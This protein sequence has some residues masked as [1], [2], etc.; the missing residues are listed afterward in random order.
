M[1]G[2]CGVLLY[3]KEGSESGVVGLQ[4]GWCERRK[5]QKSSRECTI[6]INSLAVVV[7]YDLTWVK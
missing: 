6:P 1:G 5:G 4:S 2:R 3:K 7:P